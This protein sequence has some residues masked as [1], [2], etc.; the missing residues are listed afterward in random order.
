[1]DNNV[2]ATADALAGQPQRLDVRSLPHPKA[3]LSAAPSPGGFLRSAGW[4]CAPC[5]CRAKNI[6]S[7]PVTVPDCAVGRALVRLHPP[8]VRPVV[9]SAL[10]AARSG[11][12]G[13][14]LK[15]LV[16]EAEQG[17]CDRSFASLRDL[18]RPLSVH[19]SQ[20]QQR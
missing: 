13:V 18:A 11:D 4:G 6:C 8:D 1:M 20:A 12:G 5:C 16:A 15:M 9:A 2:T 19:E 7:L 10:Q 17:C 14:T 3:E